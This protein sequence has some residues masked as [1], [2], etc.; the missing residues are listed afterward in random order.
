MLNKGDLVQVK[1]D[2]YCR[3]EGDVFTG[4]CHCFFCMN[5]ALNAVGLVTVVWTDEDD[6][7]SAI[8]EFSCG[9]NVFREPEYHTLEVLSRA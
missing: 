1:S 2:K 3:Y 9:E 5:E 8:I 4:G 6:Y 7:Q